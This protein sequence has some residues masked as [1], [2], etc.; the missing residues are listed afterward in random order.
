MGFHILG[1]SHTQTTREYSACPFTQK[2]RN[3]CAIL[4]RAGHEVIHYG[5]EGSDPQCTEQVPV[6]SLPTFFKTHRLDWRLHGF[7]TDRDP[8]NA[9]YHE[10][11]RNAI[12][13]L[14]RRV[15]FGDFLLCPYGWQHKEIAD[16]FADLIV[17]EP[18]I[19]Y[20]HTFAPYR[21]WESY[22]WMHWCY[23]KEGRSV[24]PTPSWYDAVIPG[25]F[26]LADFPF[27]HPDLPDEAGSYYLFVGRPAPAI[28]G[29]EIAR[30]V[31]RALGVPLYTAG[32]GDRSGW[33][34][35]RHLGVLSIEE[36]ARWMAGARALFCPTRYVEP[37]GNVAVEA[38]LCGTPVI[39]T[40]WGAFTETVMHGVTGYRCHTLPE[41]V[42]AACNVHTLSRDACRKWA[43]QYSLEHIGKRYCDYFERLAGVYGGERGDWYGRR[44]GGSVA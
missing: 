33:D 24:D 22:A 6:L 4:T 37:F 32:Q 16:R 38:A 29:V 7:R 41:F 28:K 44:V 19:G 30:D 25:F 43:E 40:D 17:V 13:A 15:E 35:D 11:T 39:C 27:P 34:S 23:G 18:G 20:A 42:E 12:A 2:I 26:D 21:V 3:L 31:C 8:D 10:F 36:R 9:A 5:T 14:R 1:L